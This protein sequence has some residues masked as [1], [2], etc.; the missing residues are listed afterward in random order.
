MSPS[1]SSSLIPPPPW[2][3]SGDALWVT[4]EADPDKVAEFL[5]RG[6]RPGPEPGE[7]AIGFF[8]WQWCSDNGAELLD[9]GQAQFRECL[10]VVGCS[11]DGKPAGRVPYAWVD[12][13]VPLLRGF[14]Q[15]MPKKFGS[16]WLTRSFAVGKAGPQRRQGA[17]FSAVASAGGRRIAKA[18]VTLTAP[19]DQPPPLSDRPLIHTRHF[20]AWHP[21][22]PPLAELAVG[23]TS[24]VAFADVWYGTAEL[25]FDDTGD[26]GLAA[27]APTKTGLG[28]LFSYAETLAPGRRV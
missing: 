2:H 20:P 18:T 27:L 26:P 13:A 15:G 22:E 17:Q 28:Y 9:P 8:D 16:V 21:G 25:C 3:F 23:A 14:I 1:G 5:P 6:L 7:A 24:D 10:L 11:L 12:S 4:Y 19:A